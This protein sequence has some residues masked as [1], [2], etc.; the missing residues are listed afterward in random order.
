MDFNDFVV[1]KEI[2]KIIKMIFGKV[3]CFIRLD[4]ENN[5]FK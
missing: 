5:I 3:L 2:I 1:M 4:S